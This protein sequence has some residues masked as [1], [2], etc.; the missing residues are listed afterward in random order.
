MVNAPFSLAVAYGVNSALAN[1]PGATLNVGQLE[2]FFVIIHG[3]IDAEDVR[4]DVAV[5]LFLVVGIRQNVKVNFKRDVAGVHGSLGA[6]DA[7]DDVME[8]HG[9]LKLVQNLSFDHIAAALTLGARRVSGGIVGGIDSLYR[10]GGHMAERVDYQFFLGQRLE[11]NVARVRIG[12]KELPAGGALVVRFD[13]GIRA[14]G[15]DF[16]D[17]CKAV[18]RRRASVSEVVCLQS[19]RSQT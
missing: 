3:K 16:L 7:G 15:G 6:V 14:V 10:N 5:V 11:R 12:G 19:S 8:L 9:L 1:A 2:N 13:A 4:K 18:A 17:K